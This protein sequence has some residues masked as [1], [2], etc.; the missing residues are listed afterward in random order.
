MS[1]L[2]FA[3]FI[4]LNTPYRYLFMLLLA[5]YSFVNTLVVSVFVYYPLPVGQVEVAALFLLFTVAIWEGNR[6][7]GYELSRRKLPFVRQIMYQFL[8]S[9]VLTMVV[10]VLPALALLAWENK[11]NAAAL[12]LPIRLLLL[13]A[14][15]V[16]LFLNTVNVIFRYVQQL[17]QTQLEVEQF[18]KESAQA[19]LQVIKNQVNPHFLFNS[20]SVLSALISRDTAAAEE[21]VS[22]FSQVYRYVLKSPEK[23]LVRVDEELTFTSAYIYLLEQRFGANLT[24]RITL[25]DQARRQYLVP[26]VLQMLIE[27]AVKHNIVSAGKPLLVHI[28]DEQAEVLVVQNDLQLRTDGAHESTGLGLPNIGHRYAF[29]TDRPFVVERTDGRFTVKIPLLTIHSMSD[30]LS[31]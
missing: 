27:N 28:Y 29:L 31:V 15:R 26:V 4:M 6:L 20:L 17:R 13:V 14:F 21:F 1:P 9:I 30:A 22:K 19:Q 2:P 10:T 11:L 16:N 24:V 8:A 7:I 18:R 25:S 5:V 12:G 23:E 3:L